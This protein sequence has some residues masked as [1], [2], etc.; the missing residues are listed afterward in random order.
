MRGRYPNAPQ[1][2]GRPEEILAEIQD[3][4]L[5]DCD[6]TLGKA[7]APFEESFAKLIGTKHA[8]GVGSGT[9]ALM[10]SLK[11]VGIGHGDEVITA[12]NTFIA[13]VGAI[14]AV[15]ARPVLVDVTPYFTID[16]GKIE[17]A[18]TPRTKAILPVHLTGEPADLK[19]I[20]EIA[21]RRDLAV[22]EDACQSID[23]AI[24]GRRCGTMG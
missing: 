12:A 14:N 5:K 13:T 3:Q 6:F 19:P 10:L 11:A 21:R 22:V 1:H 8:V 15:G 23:A 17:A 2:F 24:D 4:L 16:P 9:D 7:V 20:L 18:I